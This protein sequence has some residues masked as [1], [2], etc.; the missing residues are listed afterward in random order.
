MRLLSL[1]LGILLVTFGVLTEEIFE[2]GQVRAKVLS[3][4]VVGPILAEQFELKRNAG[5]ATSGLSVNGPTDSG[6][7]ERSFAVGVLPH[8]LGCVGRSFFYAKTLTTL[9]TKVHHNRALVESD[10]SPT[11]EP[12]T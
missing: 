5:P 1:C 7:G 6:Y 11:E 9:Q 2:N 3:P 10:G 12:L 4:T 8:L